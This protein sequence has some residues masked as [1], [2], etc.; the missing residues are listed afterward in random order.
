MIA[1]SSIYLCSSL[2]GALL[3]LSLL[4][5]R[6]FFFFCF[7]LLL[8]SFLFSLQT[9]LWPGNNWKPLGLGDLLD[10]KQVKLAYRKAMLVVHPDRCSNMDSETKFIAKRVFEAVNEAYQDFLKKENVA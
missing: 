2:F 8:Y 7:Y 6:F 4:L 9:V 3:L 5:F 1:S 10:P